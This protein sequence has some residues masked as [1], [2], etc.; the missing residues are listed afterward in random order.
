MKKQILLGLSLFGLIGTTSAQT[1]V[2]TSPSSRN[3][4]LEE[5]TGIY[6]T[7]CPD[8]HKRA[9]QL[10]ENNPG[11]V[12]LVNVHTGYYAAP[13]SGSGD[14][15][16]RTNY[17][18]AL[19][20]QSGLSGYPAG[21]VNRDAGLGVSYMSTGGTAMS[22]GY[23][24]TAAPVVMAE[25]SPVNIAA[26]ATIDVVTREVSILVELYYTSAPAN[27]TNKLNVAILQDN[28]AGPQT[29]ASSY[30]PEMINEDGDYVHNHML[31]DFVTGQWGE[32][33]TIANGPF[34]SRTYTYTLPA[35][36]NDIEAVL[37]DIHIAAYVN[38]DEQD[39]LTGDYATITYTG[40]TSQLDAS[41]TSYEKISTSDCGTDVTGIMAEIQNTAGTT[42]TSLDFEYTVDGASAGTYTW[43][44]SI[45]SLYTEEIELEGITYDGSTGDHEVEFTIT[46]VNGG[47]DEDLS[48]N[49]GSVSFTTTAG[50]GQLS[51]VLVSDRYASEV[52]WSI[53]NSQT[54]TVVKSVAAGTYSDGNANITYTYTD[55]VD[56]TV[57]SCFILDVVDT[58]GDG[59]TGTTGTFVAV[60]DANGDTIAYVDG[61]SYSDSTHEFYKHTFP[62]GVSEVTNSMNEVSLYPN[63]A[64]TEAYLEFSLSESK[65]VQVVVYNSVGAVV[66]QVSSTEYASGM[67]QIKLN[68]TNYTNG[69]YFVNMLVDGQ[70]EIQKLVINK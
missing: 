49:D 28:I 61:Q 69:I 6:C 66:D 10:Y 26:E 45:P 16:F 36:Y 2:S 32:T 53:T 57:E 9:N 63:P 24:S 31:R 12:V 37:E 58:Y 59:L 48:D 62:V 65:D 15:D 5:F 14:P 39:I 42:I 21:T 33:I 47:N 13:L 17:G 56:F 44:G 67:N 64:K 70:T 23:W 60:I 41:L 19:A 11:R 34:F 7:Y 20:S 18:S 22:R 1:I 46:S 54:G 51:V 4:V 50:S 38:E 52:G 55:S 35:D 40:F 27:S 68:T 43:T 25:T 30:Y 3:V 29:G 8:G